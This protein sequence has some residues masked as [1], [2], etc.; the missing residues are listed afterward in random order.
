MIRSDRSARSGRSRRAGRA[1]RSGRS[2]LSSSEVAVQIA[3]LVM[4]FVFGLVLPLAA[5]EGGSP[6]TPVQA[7]ADVKAMSPTLEDVP[8]PHPVKFMPLTMYGQDV[9]MAYMDVPPT[10]QP[11]GR[12]AVLLHGM[13]FFGE[14]WSETIEILRREGFRV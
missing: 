4:C 3:I 2:A 14:Y 5:Q 9:R 7:P 13:N 1:G 6:R 12:T 8:Y 10:G 11:N